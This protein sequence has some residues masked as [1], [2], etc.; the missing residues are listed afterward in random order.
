MSLISANV[1]E[2]MKK[3]TYFQLC[4]LTNL[5]NSSIIVHLL[6]HTQKECRH[7]LLLMNEFCRDFFHLTWEDRK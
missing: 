6:I 4:P 2:A 1:V 7:H 3:V 5:F